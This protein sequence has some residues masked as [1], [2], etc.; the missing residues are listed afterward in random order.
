MTSEV[1]CDI[2]DGL[3]TVRINRPEARNALGTTTTKSI[4]ETI[5]RVAADKSVRVL[6][7]RGEGEDFCC[8]ADINAYNNDKRVESRDLT[9]EGEM[10]QTPALL[11]SMP[12]VTIAAVRGGCAG[13][14]M[15]FALGCDFRIVS[16]NAK[17]NTAFLAVGAAGD[18]GVS[19]SL[20]RQIGAAR[21]RDL[22]FFPRKVSAREAFDLGF[23]SRVLPDAEFENGLDA[24]VAQLL[25]AAP[26]ALRALKANFLDS[27]RLPLSDFLTAEAARHFEI[28]KSED[29]MEAFAAFLEKRTPRYKGR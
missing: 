20:A 4:Y 15:G 18:M 17:F 23:A 25:G 19:W 5:K 12:A 6:V 10:F 28:F 27:E 22:C 14:G 24:M 13:A 11:H 9:N 8:G 1:L 3:A 26:L 29:R 21:A 16:E 7:L 2:A